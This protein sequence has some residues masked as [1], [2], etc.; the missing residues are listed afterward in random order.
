MDQNT[1]RIIE[2][3]NKYNWEYKILN[4]VKIFN[5]L[6]QI[7]GFFPI[8]ICIYREKN[9]I[10]SIVSYILIIISC[11]ITNKQLKKIYHD[12]YMQYLQNILNHTNFCRSIHVN[13]TKKIILF[14]DVKYKSKHYDYFLVKP[15]KCYFYGER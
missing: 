11:K 10:F 14:I 1:K 6:L 9:V 7:A 2:I 12:Q 15:D 5:K 3:I 8:L 13:L 4:Y